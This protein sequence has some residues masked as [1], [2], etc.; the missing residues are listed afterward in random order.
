MINVYSITNTFIA[1]LNIGSVGCGGTY[2][3]VHVQC[4]YIYIDV[5]THIV[6]C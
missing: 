5:Y 2:V 3:C 1:V 4:I 6:V